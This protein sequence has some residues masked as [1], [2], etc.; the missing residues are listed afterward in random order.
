[1]GVSI[2]SY[3][4]YALSFN[5]ISYVSCVYLQHS[6]Y[7]FTL[8]ERNVIAFV[9]NVSFDMVVLTEN[10]LSITRENLPFG[11]M[12]FSVSETFIGLDTQCFV[13]RICQSVFEIRM[14]HMAIAMCILIVW[15]W[16]E[17]Y[18]HQFCTRDRLKEAKERKFWAIYLFIGQVLDQ[19][20]VYL[21]HMRLFNSY[22]AL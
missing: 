6:I 13:C 12:Q 14:Y 3:I 1:M 17:F 5:G 2:F 9:V 22:Y 7:L 16:T 4:L 11:G 15:N 8:T 21:C 19:A 18:E 20:T 10:I